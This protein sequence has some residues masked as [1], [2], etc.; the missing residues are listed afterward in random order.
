MVDTPGL[1]DIIDYRSKITRDYID[2]ANAVLICVNAKTLRNEEMLTIARVFSKAKYKKDKIYILGTQI[3]TMNSFENWLTQ[4]EEWLKILRREEYFETMLKAKT[5][6]LGISSYAYSKAITIKTE[7]TED[8]I[9]DLNELK[10]MNREEARKSRKLVEDGLYTKEMVCELK[11][12]I[13]NYSRIEH[14]RDIIQVE[15]LKDFNDSLVKD[16]VEKYKI[17]KS[18][19]N[20]FG[21]K[22]KEILEDKKKELEMTSEELTKKIEAERERVREIEKINDTLE[23]KIR[24]TTESFNLDF[25][26]LEKSFKELEEKIKEINID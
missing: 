12:R 20:L 5:H 24:E 1:N 23:E 21:K 10:L 7:L 14:L 25:S 26:K 18:E 11:E 17:L 19:I 16:F 2:S 3:D 6:L 9:W 8:D 4:R 22:H 13:I 15:L